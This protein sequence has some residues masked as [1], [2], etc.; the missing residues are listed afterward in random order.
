M[1]INNQ[2]TEIAT[3]TLT[4]VFNRRQ[5]F[6]YFERFVREQD[7]EQDE[8]T[9]AVMVLDIDSFKSI[10]D[11]Y[12]HSMGDEAIITVARSLETEFQWNDFICR[13]GGDEFVVITRH[14]N[15]K[16]LELAIERVNSSFSAALRAKSASVRAVRQRRIRT[17]VQAEQYAG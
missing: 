3:D 8:G 9:V 2:N 4:G 15:T 14:G 17:A 13:F 6:V 5:A 12:G 11:Q 1:F 10:N 7:K 16:S